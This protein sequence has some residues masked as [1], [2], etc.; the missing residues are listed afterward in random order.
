[1]FLESWLQTTLGILFNCRSWKMHNVRPAQVK[2]GIRGSLDRSDLD[3][4]FKLN[5]KL[6]IFQDLFSEPCWFEGQDKNWVDKDDRMQPA[7]LLQRIFSGWKG[8]YQN[9]RRQTWYDFSMDINFFKKM[10]NTCYYSYRVQ[11]YTCQQWGHWGRGALYL[12]FYLIDIRGW[13]IIRVISWVFI[14][15]VVRLSCSNS[16]NCEKAFQL[17][18]YENLHYNTPLSS[19][20]ISPISNEVEY[21]EVIKWSQ[22]DQRV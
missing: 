18:N 6:N 19:Q 11:H 14:H 13:G 3:H 15:H 20:P 16:D 10:L 12:W 8:G 1:M 2:L 4:L 17:K 9:F 7:L 22:T 5:F 21:S